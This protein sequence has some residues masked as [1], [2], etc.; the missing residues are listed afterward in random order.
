MGVPSRSPPG[1]VDETAAL[2]GEKYRGG[3]GAVA[4][5]GAAGRDH[6][7]KS[8]PGGSLLAGAR[9]DESVV[10]SA[11]WCNPGAHIRRSG[12]DG[13]ALEVPYARRAATCCALGL[14]VIVAVAGWTSGSGGVD[15]AAAS[16][17]GAGVAAGAGDGK[18]KEGRTVGEDP[19]TAHHSRPESDSL[20]VV[21]GQTPAADEANTANAVDAAEAG[22][23]RL[24]FPTAMHGDGRGHWGAARSSAFKVR[25]TVAQAALGGAH[26]GGDGSRACE[27]LGKE[28]DCAKYAADSRQCSFTENWRVDSCLRLTELP[29]FFKVVDHELRTQSALFPAAKD[30]GD[31]GLSDVA[32]VKA[33]AGA[34]AGS[35]S[36]TP[37]QPRL[38]LD[39]TGTPPLSPASLSAA[40]V[41]HD[42]LPYPEWLS[43][44]YGCGE[45]MPKGPKCT[46]PGV[47]D[48]ALIPYLISYALYLNTLCPVPYTPYPLP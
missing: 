48:P 19:L 4:W 44:Y 26:S 7:K 21:D 38:P 41:N 22:N 45:E 28:G 8:E 47:L 5:G 1:R 11:R 25:A 14:V 40:R 24:G 9:G 16:L 31:T 27:I 23:A 36:S 35:E 43:T 15:T 18:W 34:V 2:T 12:D 3:G 20:S 46:K 32:G 33:A 17:G 37:E 42:W 29:Q 6:Q 30:A 39:G 13:G 10:R